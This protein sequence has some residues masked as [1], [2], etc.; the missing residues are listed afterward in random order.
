MAN[1]NR[2]STFA[3]L[4]LLALPAVAADSILA[5]DRGLPQNNLNDSS[6]SA[7]SNVRWGW[8][9]HGFL[10]DDFT[11]GARGEHWVI[12]AIRTWTVP[13]HPELTASR[14]GDFY[15]DVRLYVGTGSADLTPVATAPLSAGS[16][17]TGSPNVVISEATANGALLYD[18]FGTGLRIWQIDFK[19]LSIPVQGGSKTRFGVWG[20]GR[21]MPGTD[22]KTYTWFNHASNAALSGSRQD[23]ADGVMLKFDAAGRSEG[24]LNAEGNAWDK[25]ADINVQVFAHRVDASV[26]GG[27]TRA[28]R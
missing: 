16:D 24:T 28:D 17:E 8:N 6:G 15:Q 19:N 3:S 22:G 10:G 9:D 14:L 26:S 25:P 2:F 27:A 12:D 20:M 5:V 4:L 11:V 1:K 21:A 7:R 23:G 13:G 18:D